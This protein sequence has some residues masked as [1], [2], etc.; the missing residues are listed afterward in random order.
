M[1][2][3]IQWTVLY[4]NVCP[5]KGSRYE[6]TIMTRLD[7]GLDERLSYGL[8]TLVDTARQGFRYALAGILRNMY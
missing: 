5:L 2:G 3:L 1:L 4:A 8:D 7:F 6:G